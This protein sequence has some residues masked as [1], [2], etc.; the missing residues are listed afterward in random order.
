MV[1]EMNGFISW[2]WSWDYSWKN[3]CVGV[4]NKRSTSLVQTRKMIRKSSSSTDWRG[5]DHFY[6]N[7]IGQVFMVLLPPVAFAIRL[8]SF[9]STRLTPMAPFSTK[10]LVFRS[11]I[12]PVVRITFAPDAKIFST[13]SFVISAS[14]CLMAE[15]KVLVWIPLNNMNFFGTTDLGVFLDHQQ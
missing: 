13:R 10:Y 3:G 14:R 12:P 1:A 5:N 8:R 9:L 4:C 6:K 11:S 15:S 7:T 2:R